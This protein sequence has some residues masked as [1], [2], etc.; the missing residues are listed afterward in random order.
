MMHLGDKNAPKGVG[1]R[2]INANKIEFNAIGR[3]RDHFDRE[4]LRKMPS[5]CV[6][7]LDLFIYYTGI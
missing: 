4:I 3:N 7:L 6:Y 5:I 1:N 2:G